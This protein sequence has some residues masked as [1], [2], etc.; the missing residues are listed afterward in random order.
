M[1]EY[2]RYFK[3]TVRPLRACSP[4]SDAFRIVEMRSRLGAMSEPRRSIVAEL[5]F[6]PVANHH[7]TLFGGAALALMD[8]VAFVAAS[9]ALRQPAVTA[10]VES[11][12]FEAPL[13]VGTLAEAEATGVRLEGRKAF[14]EVEL[15]RENLVSGERTRC[16]SGEFLCIALQSAP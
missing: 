12:R 5:V 4:L 6:P 13:E 8:K 15:W 16:A 10:G 2:Q 7:G 3:V 9:R 1:Q 11:V 14:V